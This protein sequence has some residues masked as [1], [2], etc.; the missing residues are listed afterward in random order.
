MSVRR[1]IRLIEEESGRWAA[2]DEERGITAR[3]ESAEDAL[4]ELENAVSGADE[5]IEERG[6]LGDRLRGMADDLDVDPVEDVRET[7]ERA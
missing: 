2:T 6:S 4:E 5:E 1:E 3:G 7:R